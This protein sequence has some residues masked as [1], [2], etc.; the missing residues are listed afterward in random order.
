MNIYGRTD[1]E[2]EILILWPP[3][4]KSWPIWKEPDAEKG[5]MVGW[6]HRLNGHEFEWA[7]GIGDG[8]ENL[9]CCIPWGRR[10]GHNWA[11]ELNWLTTTAI[12]SPIMEK[13]YAESSF[14]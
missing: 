6:H 4:A 1:A 12:L 5:E 14:H 13:K 10:V 3:D 7:L 2:A 8:Q 9:A 11:T